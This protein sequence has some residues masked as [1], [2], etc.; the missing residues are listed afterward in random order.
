M[1]WVPDSAPAQP[2][3]IS[4]GKEGWHLELHFQA[5]QFPFSILHAG[6]V[7]SVSAQVLPPS[8]LEPCAPEEN[9]E[10]PQGSGPKVWEEVLPGAGLI[11]QNRTFDGV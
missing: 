10:P 4:L 11:K 3:N 9:P 2:W 8:V 5:V 1:G 6:F 7:H